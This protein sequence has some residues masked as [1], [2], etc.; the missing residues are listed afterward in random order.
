MIRKNVNVAVIQQGKLGGNRR[1]LTFVG[2]VVVR[3]DRV[4]G[5]RS[6]ER[7]GGCLIM[8]IK[9]DLVYKELNGWKGNTTEGMRVVIDVSKNER[10]IIT[11][12]YRPPV[13]RIEGEYE[14]VREWLESNENELI[15]GNLNLHAK[16]WSDGIDRREN[17][18]AKDVI[19]WCS[20]NDYRI[21][22]G[23]STHVD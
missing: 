18:L 13:R 8:V 5:R 7:I 12:V 10:I 16:E 21:L 15:L 23:M 17:G 11:N 1:T 6:R 4:N 3:K 9:K 14:R 2:Y 22:N 20:E 19:W